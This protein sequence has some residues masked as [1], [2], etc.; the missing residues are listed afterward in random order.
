MS[1]AATAARVSGYCAVRACSAI[2]GTP[3]PAY[4]RLSDHCPLVIEITNTDADQ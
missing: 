4:Q 3:P 1:E 2:N